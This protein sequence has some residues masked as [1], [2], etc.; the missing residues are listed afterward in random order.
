[1]FNESQLAI[2]RRALTALAEREMNLNNTVS[3]D[4]ANL[5]SELAPAPVAAPAPAPVVEEP[6]VE[7][8]ADVVEPTEEEVEAHFAKTEDK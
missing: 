1:M 7:V 4:V 5:I 2:I 6:V 8:P 3:D